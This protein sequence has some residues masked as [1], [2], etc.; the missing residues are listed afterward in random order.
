MVYTTEDKR[1]LSSVS[2]LPAAV[3]TAYRTVKDVQVGTLN[4]DYVGGRWEKLTG[5]TPE[6]T[7][8]DLA[9]FFEN[10][11]PEDLPMMMLNINGTE[12]ANFEIRYHHPVTKKTRWFQVSSCPRRKGG[13]IVG[14]G[15]LLDVT[16]RKEAEQ[17]LLTEMERLERELETKRKRL[18]TLKRDFIAF[19]KELSENPVM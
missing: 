6:E 11:P 13:H 8:A 17:K 15:F 2:H 12:G 1:V 16:A 9:N 10:I 3:G 7:K 4:F 18:Q 19:E 5:V 14:D